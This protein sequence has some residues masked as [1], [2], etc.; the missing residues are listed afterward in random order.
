MG[1]KGVTGDLGVGNME[2]FRTFYGYVVDMLWIVMDILWIVDGYFMGLSGQSG[3]IEPL[4]IDDCI[5]AKDT[6]ELS[7]IYGL[8][9]RTVVGISGQ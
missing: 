2:T 4:K 7:K 8:K 1:G 3:T 9:H 5:S 6:S